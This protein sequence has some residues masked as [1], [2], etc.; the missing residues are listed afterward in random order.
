MPKNR[1]RT[2]ALRQLA[3]DLLGSLAQEEILEG[4]QA[5]LVTSLV[6]QWVTYDGS[7]TLF[8]GGQQVYLVLD[9]TPL[10]KPC[11]V[12]EPALPL[13][14]WQARLVADW[15]IAPEDLPE[16]FDQLNRGQSAEVTNGE[17]LPVRLW[18]NPRERSRG[19]EPLVK[20]P[21]PPGRKRDYR[22]IAADLLEQAFGACLTQRRARPSPAPWSGSG[23]STRDTPASS[24][25]RSSSFSSSP[26]WR[27]ETAA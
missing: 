24:T 21:L 25:G 8:L 23:S 13:P 26:S 18:V 19:V 27:G 3:E 6:R 5:E 1:G 15:K 22:K 9:R 4:E 14:G 7:A 17:G 2:Q 10:G 16:V 20:E 12:P 11:I